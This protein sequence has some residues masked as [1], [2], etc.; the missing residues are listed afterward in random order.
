MQTAFTPT[1]RGAETSSNR[2]TPPSVKRFEQPSAKSEWADS[3]LMDGHD[4]YDGVPI[5]RFMKEIV[6]SQLDV[7]RMDYMIRDQANTVLKSVAL[8]APE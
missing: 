5:P 7:D 2:Q 1:K 3:S 6:S 8:T 4:E